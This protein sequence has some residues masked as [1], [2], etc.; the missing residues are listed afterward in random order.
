MCKFITIFLLLLLCVSVLIGCADD[1]TAET[2]GETNE[3]TSQTTEFT[4]NENTEASKA[5][6]EEL[7]EEATEFDA[8][9]MAEIQTK[10]HQDGALC[11]VAYVGYCGGSFA[12]VQTGFAADGL[13]EALPI[14]TEV[15]EE[16]FLSVEGSELYL[17]VPQDDVALTVYEQILEEDALVCGATLYTGSAEAL[18]LRGNI[19]DIFSNLVLLI[20]GRDG[21]ALE[22]SPSLSMKNGMLNDGGSLI[23]DMTP[24]EL[25]GIYDGPETGGEDPRMGSWFAEVPNTAGDMMLLEL[26]LSYDGAASYAYGAVN[27]ELFESFE[28]Q[29]YEEDGKLVLELF[30]GLLYEPESAYEY[31]ASFEFAYG[32]YCL[33]LTHVDGY[34]LVYGLEGGTISFASSNSYALIGQW[35][36]SECDFR[37]NEYTYYDLDLM[38]D[39]LCN[40]LIH[41]GEGTTYAAY[42]GRWDVA[43]GTLSLDLTMF[44]GNDFTDSSVQTFAGEYHAVID[45]DG[46]LTL[47]YIGGDG[48]TDYM[49][50]CGLE[51]FEPM[52]S[53]G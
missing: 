52:V 25:L 8:T 48:L 3:K 51:I 24:Y 28:G 2:M 6:A 1:K 49:S 46:W 36:T 26:V 17:I 29:W 21:E 43:D 11:A 13:T 14:L 19:S 16:N 23:C 5:P 31:N 10:L 37:T 4:K 22:Y 40:L 42:E 27:S 33:S 34:S 20:E 41:N 45:A 39:N 53:Y 7:T 38:G 50:E 47:H 35:S 32:D 9:A 18:L 44:S 12:E 30:G 15:K